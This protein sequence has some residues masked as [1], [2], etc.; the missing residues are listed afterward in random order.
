MP[1]LI[2]YDTS[3]NSLYKPGSATDFF[4]YKPYDSYAAICAEMSRLVYF[5]ISSNVKFSKLK[6]FLSSGGFE[7][8]TYVDIKGSQAMLAGNDD[9]VILS[10]RGTEGDDPRDLW[11][12]IN[13]SP[14]IWKLHGKP[15]GKVHG[16]FAKAL[17]QVWNKTVTSIPKDNRKLLLTGHSLGAAMA[18]LAATRLHPHGLYT[19]GSPQVGDNNFINNLKNMNHERYVNCCD[20]VTR[21]PL[22]VFGFKH[23]GTLLYINRN[24]N[25][26]KNPESKWIK[27]DRD[28][29]ITDY[30]KHIAWKFSSITIRDLADH[31][32]INYLSAVLRRRKP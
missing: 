12:D 21:I 11:T 20:L 24:G 28:I 26:R 7:L 3:R 27:K 22:D 25:I 31:T 8:I 14:R 6:N 29:A 9:L 18:T 5:S 13:F 30:L 16:G 2:P 4:S 17:G 32:P 1:K 19:F 23:T 10:F 15:S